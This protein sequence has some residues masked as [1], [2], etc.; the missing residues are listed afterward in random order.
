LWAG[1][2]LP[3][4]NDASNHRYDAYTFPNTSSAAACVT[5]RLYSPLGINLQP[6]A[7]TSAYTPTPAATFASSSAA[8]YLGEAGTTGVVEQFSVQLPAN[9]N[10]IVVV[11]DVPTGVVTDVPYT[12]EVTG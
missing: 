4:V 9:T 12:L 6:V 3:G 7:Y 10:L 5:I 8:A 2:V 11:N 1:Q